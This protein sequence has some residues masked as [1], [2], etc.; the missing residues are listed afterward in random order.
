MTTAAA[1]AA[2]E[3][4]K[5]QEGTT[6]IGNRKFIKYRVVDK[7]SRQAIS[8]HQWATIL[9]GSSTSHSYDDNV[10]VVDSSKKN[11][12]NKK[13]SAAAATAASAAATLQFNQLL[14][15]APYQAFYWETPPIIPRNNY[16]DDD[17]TATTT[18]A[19]ME[20]VLVDA[21]DLYAFARNKPDTNAFAEH[22]R[23][24]NNNSPTFSSTAVAVFDNLGKDA[25]LVA[26][27]PIKG[28]S[29]KTYSDLAAFCRGA[30]L[31]QIEMVWRTVAEQYLQQ[32]QTSTSTTKTT[33]TEKKPVVWL[34]TSG[35]GV[36][37]LHFRFDRRPKYYTYKPYT[38]VPATTST[39]AAAAAATA[40]NKNVIRPITV[41]RRRRGS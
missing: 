17:T 25:K 3:Y 20:F 23:N 39:T 26:P 5:M 33:T 8:V 7:T 30:T 13:A 36:A 27:K 38:T 35:G 1:A 24:N 10:V 11:A 41:S 28:T 22:F 34:S 9:A 32:M 6:A 2:W 16:D 19:M 12:K 29:L 4:E 31:P 14:A 15:S 21:P 37:W 40:D 18:T